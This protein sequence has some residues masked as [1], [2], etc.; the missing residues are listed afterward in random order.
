MSNRSPPN[1]LPL[2]SRFPGYEYTCHRRS[3]NRSS[4]VG[5]KYEHMQKKH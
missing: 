2:R 1:P 5:D 3:V 4:V